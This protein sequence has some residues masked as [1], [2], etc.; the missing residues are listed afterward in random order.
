MYQYIFGKGIPLPFSLCT[1]H[2]QISLP[3]STVGHRSLHYYKDS[4][5]MVGTEESQDEQAFIQLLS[6]SMVSNDGMTYEY[7]T[8]LSMP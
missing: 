8:S 1:P 3:L 5:V 6:S 7:G 4:V 2:L